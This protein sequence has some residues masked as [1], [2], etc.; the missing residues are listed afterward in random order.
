[1][2]IIVHKDKIIK[3]SD[4]YSVEDYLR[5][6]TDTF[7]IEEML[8]FDVE[9]IAVKIDMSD[10]REFYYKETRDSRLTHIYWEN[11]ININNVEEEQIGRKISQ[12]NKVLEITNYEEIPVDDW[13]LYRVENKNNH[14]LKLTNKEFD[15]LAGENIDPIAGAIKNVEKNTILFFD[16]HV[17]RQ[18]TRYLKEKWRELKNNGIKSNENLNMLN[19]G[20]DRV[21][22][23][24]GYLFYKY[25][26]G[27]SIVVHTS[28]LGEFLSIYEDE[29]VANDNGIITL[30]N[31]NK[32]LN[33]ITDEI[34]KKRILKDS[35]IR[36]YLKSKKFGSF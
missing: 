6:H 9:K 23:S 33:N 22:I 1:M 5:Q 24:N 36:A 20:F 4:D 28:E 31:M 19:D 3:E 14:R 29:W 32:Y 30:N 10:H 17:D 25:S 18:Q 27:Q 12:I 34:D 2:H 16:V 11:F 35:L 13:W 8:V 21:G 26:K 7:N 15:L